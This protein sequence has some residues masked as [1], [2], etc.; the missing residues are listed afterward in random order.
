V[1]AAEV[2]AAAERAYE[3]ALAYAAGSRSPW[4]LQLV[5]DASRL[6]GTVKWVEGDEERRRIDEQ[7]QEEER[8]GR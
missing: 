2:R 5:D 7:K 1:T 3:A 6:L 8:R 4:A